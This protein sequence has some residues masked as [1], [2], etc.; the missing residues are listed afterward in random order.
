MQRIVKIRRTNSLFR[1]LPFVLA[2]GFS[3][4][5]T[6]CIEEKPPA[7]TVVEAQGQK[8]LWTCGMHPQV[9]VE[10]PGFCPI[11]NMKLTPVKQE[12]M[13]AVTVSENEHADHDQLTQTMSA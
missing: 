10:E 11:C 5:S 2:V 9:V 6:G 12:T 3:T 1:Y 8:Q 7:L 13:A 4:F